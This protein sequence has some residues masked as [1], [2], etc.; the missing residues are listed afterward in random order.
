MTPSCPTRR[1]SDLLGMGACNAT[2]QGPRTRR[3]TDLDVARITAAAPLGDQAVALAALHQHHRRLVAGLQAFGQL[4]DRAPAAPVEAVLV[5]QQQKL[6][7]RPACT[8]EHSVGAA[9]GSTGRSGGLP[10]LTRIKILN[11]H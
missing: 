1:S 9:W 7:R 5:Q 3:G 6:P 11:T 8:D 4:A 2:H 10:S